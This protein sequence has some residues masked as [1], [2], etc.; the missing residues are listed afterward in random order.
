M[1]ILLVPQRKKSARSQ[2][3]ADVSTPFGTLLRTLRQAPGPRAL[4]LRALAQKV[5]V[6]HTYLSALETGRERKP[7]ADLLDKITA[8]LEL[9]QANKQRLVWAATGHDVLV[10]PGIPVNVGKTLERQSQPDVQEVWVAA[11]RPLETDAEHLAAVVSNIHR[12]VSY[13]YFIHDRHYVW[14]MLVQRLRQHVSEEILRERVLALWVAD[15]FLRAFLFHPPFAL[16][17]TDTGNVVGVLANRSPVVSRDQRGNIDSV[18][19]MVTDSAER[20]R[21]QLAPV[22]DSARANIELPKRFKKVYPL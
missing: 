9:N 6:N 22:I 1:Q 11:E 7:S 19:E 21:E 10:A 2:P 13:V 4:S 14:P 18:M 16:I 17:H 12:G 15:P 20:R 5:G 8:A 3:E